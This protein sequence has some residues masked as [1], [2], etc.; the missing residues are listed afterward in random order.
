MNAPDRFAGIRS[1]VL[2]RAARMNFFQLCQLLE[3]LDPGRA[4]LGT[5]DTP[6]REPVRFRPYPK[7]GF[8]GTEVAAVEFDADRPDTPPS[9]RTTFLGLYG[10]N[11]AMPPHLIDDIVLRREGHE[12]VMAFLDVF[13]HRI[14]TLFYRA[15]RK[16]RYWAAFERGGTDDISRSLLCLAGFGLGDK[17]GRAGLPA[18][19]VLGLLG[20]L[21]QRTRTAEG[22]AGVIALAVPG[23]G[24]RIDER[25]PVWVRLDHQPGLRPGRPSAQSG[26][27]SFA[28]EGLGRGHVLGRRVI[29]RAE[30]VRVTLS[31]A[32]AAQAHGLLPGA[33]LHRDLMSLL[34]VYLGHK[35]DVV[36]RMEVSAAV[37][38][39]LKIGGTRTIGAGAP[40]HPP[41][42][43]LAWTTLLK[44][45]GDRVIT[46]PLG[47]YEAIPKAAAARHAAPGHAA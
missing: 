16:Y 22:L 18:A 21:T 9:V 8:P 40:E 36:L 34:R 38:P 29:N 30:A 14:A 32:S 11:A 10:V 7:T 45:A 33:L 6:A 42:G 3:R 24:V 47:R 15:W 17:A 1:V 19:R 27:Q 43:R 37:A 39:V 20:L 46:I 35:A 4:G 28:E 12:E 44:P 41:G 23:A 13:N 2:A 26:Q 31:P 25:F 5:H